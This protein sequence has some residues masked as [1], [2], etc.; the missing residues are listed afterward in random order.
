MHME[1][2][3]EGCER[4]V[5]SEGNLVGTEIEVEKKE[6]RQGGRLQGMGEGRERQACSKAKRQR[7]NETARW[8][9]ATSKKCGDRV[10]DDGWRS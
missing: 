3:G 4:K 6:L 8:L 5:E 9:P 7:G 10:R 1:V 2:D